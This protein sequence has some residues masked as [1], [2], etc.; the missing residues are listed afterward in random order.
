MTQVA[1]QPAKAQ[2]VRRMPDFVIVGAMRSGTTSLFRYLSAHP[3]VFMPQKEL[4]FFDRHFDRGLLWYGNQFAQATDEQQVGEATPSYM[5]LPAVAP[6]LAQTLPR[7][8]LIAV[9]RNPVDRAYSHYW[10]ARIWG[11]EKGDFDSVAVAECERL[12]SGIREARAPYSYIERGLYLEQLDRIAELYPRDSLHVLLLDDLHAA[13][14]PTY[15]A[16]CR[17]LSIEPHQVAQ[18]VG[19]IHNH[20]VRFRV[21]QRHLQRMA[22]R[23]LPAP[24]RRVVKKINSRSGSYPPMN[25]QTRARLIDFFAP[26]NHKLSQ[27]LN[28]DLSL[29][30]A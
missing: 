18:D 23:H 15:D 27:W 17:F 19:S 25:E 28:R 10:H 6:R 29:W 9:L 4:H 5:F 13:L 12:A 16:I 14:Q 8:R 11:P 24:I 26:H 7:A 3:D 20:Y 30:N 22:R 21:R 1:K 2:T